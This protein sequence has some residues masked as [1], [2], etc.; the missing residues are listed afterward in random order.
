MYVKVPP[1]HTHTHTES[2]TEKNS[3]P[4]EHSQTEHVNLVILWHVV[5]RSRSRP[6]ERGRSLERGGGGSGEK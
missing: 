5:A 1:P 2:T 4:E 3:Q 6:C